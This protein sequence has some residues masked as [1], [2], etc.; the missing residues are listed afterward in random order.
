MIT[1]IVNER[2]NFIPFLKR[3]KDGREV[4]LPLYPILGKLHL[5]EYR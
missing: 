2:H 3:L 5:E 4:I 1:M